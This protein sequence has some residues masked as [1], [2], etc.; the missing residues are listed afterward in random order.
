[1]INTRTK[2][3]IRIKIALKSNTL[4]RGKR[5]ASIPPINAPNGKDALDKEVR[6][7]MTRPS[8]LVGVII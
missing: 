2:P 5:N 7:D 4:S 1:M 6:K 8:K 3:L